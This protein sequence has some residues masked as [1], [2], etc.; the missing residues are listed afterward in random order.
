MMRIT[1]VIVFVLGVHVYAGSYGQ[2]GKVNLTMNSSLR[3]V[4][5]KLEEVSGYH[6]V[7]KYDAEILDKKVQVNYANE[8]IE[9]VLDNLLK[10]TGLSYRIID[11]YIAITSNGEY[12]SGTQQSKNISGKVVDS[13]GAPL[14]GVTVVL[15]GTTQGTI[16]SFEGIYTLSNVPANG[17]LVFSFVGMKTQEIIV[18]SQSSVNVTLTEDAIG[19]EEVVAIGYGTMKKSDLTGSVA[20][21]KGEALAEIPGATVAQS[22]QGRTAGVFVQQNTGAPGAAIQIRIRGN[23]SILGNNEPLWVVDGFPVSSANMVNLSDIESIDVLKDASATAIFGSRGANGVVIVTTKRGKAGKTK[24][25]YEGSFSIQ[26]LRKKFDMCDAQEYMQLMNI[27]Q[28]NDFGAEYFTQQE[29][30]AAG[31]GT[32]WQDLIY[33]NAPIHNHALNISGGN[34]KTKFAIG[35]SYFDQQGII[36]NSGY[37]RTTFRTSVDHQISKIFNVSSNTVISRASGIDKDDVGGLRG[38]NLLQASFCATPTVGPYNEDGSYH[39]LNED[40]PFSATGFLNPVA[41]INERTAKYYINRIMSNLT[42]T[43]KP[44]KDLTIITSGNVQNTET[45]SDGYVTTEYPN[46]TG[47]ASISVRNTMELTSN[48]TIS[49][50]KKIGNHSLSVMAGSTYEKYKT[51]P[52]SVAGTGYINDVLETY[53][54]GSATVLDIPSSSY[55]EWNLLSFLGR[56][57]YSYG[58]KYL[59]TATI[60]RDGSSRYSEG[61]K[62]GTFPSAALAWKISNEDFMKDIEFIS[63]LKLRAGYGVTGSTAISAYSTINL[64]QS[65]SAVLDKQYLSGFEP[66]DRYP[67]DLKWETTAQTNVGFD[68]SLFNNKIQLVAD[69]YVKNTSDLLNEVQ[70]SPSSGYTTT[71]KNVGKIRNKGLEFQL[72]AFLYDTKDFKWNVSANIAFNRNEVVELYNHQDI[73]GAT[74]SLA[75]VGDYVNLIR[76]GQPF[77]VFYGYREAGY[78]DN[79]KILFY[80]SAGEKVLKSGLTENDKTYIGDPNPDFTYSFNS[81]AS[82]K[83]FSL[84]IF[85]QGVQGNDLM[86]LSEGSANYDYG[87]GLNMFKEVLYDH[88]TPENT[89]AKYPKITS[90]NTY[91]ISDRF[92]HDGSYIR[93]KNIELAYSIPTKNMGIQW[94]SKGQVF[95]SGQNLVTITNYPFWDP[96]VNSRGGDNS[97]NQ[98]IDHFSYPTAKSVMV[99]V[100]F[101]F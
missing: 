32:D 58:G 93:L 83:N 52:L 50:D 27:Q 89:D 86:C 87:W 9:N 15:K 10:D 95:L 57:N 80:N 77:G 18:G 1:A 14:P 74:Y 17:I 13:T 69:Y 63:N 24:V 49:Y 45:R 3:D 37:N 51:T 28:L 22:L 35:G 40:Y 43:I 21:V 5:E 98:G 44:V 82:Y 7:L 99:G 25:T 53:D 33:R 60:R 96:D 84:S 4:F 62:W 26:Q 71:M 29:I 79:G 20:S 81:A 41:Y 8:K 66:R 75:W 30:N 36:K 92:V 2:N 67:G 65:V 64:L 101:E 61:S 55:S 19:I 39:R 88:W 78:D 6:F 56:V 38:S 34:D 76:E 54:I 23:N 97:F 42:F 94:F 90:T 72:D 68:L 100:R 70:L 85:I 12:V 47:H 48:N 46:S 16:T 73:L 59:A 31:E 11:R 91:A